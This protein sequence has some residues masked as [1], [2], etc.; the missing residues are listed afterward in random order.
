MQK[1]SEK[2]VALYCR[3]ATKRTDSLNL[4]NQIKLLL[5]YA[6][7]RGLDT[8][9]LYADSGASGITLDRPALGALKADIEAGRVSEVAV[10]NVS[11]IA[12][13]FTLYAQFEE[14]AKSYG[15]GIVGIKDSGAAML[16]YTDIAA[17]YR[18]SLK[19]GARA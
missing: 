17:V 9:M 1:Q 16:R 19:G 8:F 6:K 4:G 14:W 7:E 10:T 15:V 12:R 5:C 11:R 2:A 18:S 13:N 3:T